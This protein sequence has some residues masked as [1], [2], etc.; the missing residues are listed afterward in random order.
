MKQVS[1]L[2]MCKLRKVL[3]IQ[4]L[5]QGPWQGP[6]QMTL[7]PC[8]ELVLASKFIG[9]NTVGN[10]GRMSGMDEVSLLPVYNDDMDQV[11]KVFLTFLETD[12]FPDGHQND[13]VG[14]W[15]ETTN[16]LCLGKIQT[17]ISISVYCQAN[18]IYFL[19][20]SILLLEKIKSFHFFE[21][22][23]KKHF[24]FECLQS[25]KCNINTIV[26]FRICSFQY[27]LEGTHT[28]SWPKTTGTYHCLFVRK[29]SPSFSELRKYKSAQFL[30]IY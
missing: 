10:F 13:W 11:N 4:T 12:H 26:S 6:D 8:V 16:P 29:L 5:I 22:Q 24:L 20:L 23:H 25:Q 27:F 21:P 15:P 1:A 18:E 17:H 2:Q 7:P 30:V 28:D 14:G 3:Q 19:N 9:Q